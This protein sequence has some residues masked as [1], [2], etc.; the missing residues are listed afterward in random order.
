LTVNPFRSL[1][2]TDVG[3]GRY[4]LRA[5]LLAFLPALLLFGVRVGLGEVPLVPDEAFAWSFAAYSVFVAP[6]VETA[7]MLAFAWLLARTL[8]GRPT[9]HVVMLAAAFALLHVPGGGVAQAIGVAWPFIVYS[10]VM[11]AWRARSPQIAFLITTAVHAGYNAA[12]LAAGLA[13]A[14]L[15]RNP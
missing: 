12:F 3:L 8:P 7:L 11:V 10:A 5:W 15:A 9:A 1:A 13:T 2:D 14:A 6:A 4:V